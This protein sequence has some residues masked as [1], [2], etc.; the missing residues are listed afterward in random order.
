MGIGTS[1]VERE[2]GGIVDNSSIKTRAIRISKNI[3]DLCDENTIE[4]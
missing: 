1:S 2:K 3:W 4:G